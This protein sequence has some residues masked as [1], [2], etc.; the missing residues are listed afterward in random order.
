MR[1]YSRLS[2]VLFPLSL[3]PSKRILT[4]LR[5][6]LRRSASRSILSMLSL[7][8]LASCSLRRR[9]SRSAGDSSGGGWRATESGSDIERRLPEGGC[10]VLF[11][12]EHRKEA[13]CSSTR[14]TRKEAAARAPWA[15]G[16]TL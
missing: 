5:L 6:R 9:P 7:R 3:W 2:V 13:L 12:M 10:M 14:F 11:M 15:E 4:A 16:L 1:G 8:F